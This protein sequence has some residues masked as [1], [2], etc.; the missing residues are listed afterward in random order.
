ARA[1]FQRCEE[2]GLIGWHPSWAASQEPSLL[3]EELSRLMAIAKY[4]LLH[5]RYHYLRFQLPV[6]YQ[7]LL[8]LGIR[9]E[10]SMGYGNINGFRASYADSYPWFD[11]SKNEVTDL[12]VHPFFY[13]DTVS[14]FQQQELPEA[15]LNFIQ[16]TT[17]SCRGL[18]RELQLVF[19]PHA[20][21]GK[22]RRDVLTKILNQSALIQHPHL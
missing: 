21:A 4:P 22:G 7:Q 9:H 3:Q 8:Q 18:V 6:S 1:I 20:L 10:H 12:V 2:K 17:A 16:N 11:L 5:S 14:V 13:M 15:A 19:H